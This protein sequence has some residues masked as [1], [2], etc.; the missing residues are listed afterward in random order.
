ML[1]KITLKDYVFSVLILGLFVLLVQANNKMHDLKYQ[2][3]TLV[4]EAEKPKARYAFANHG[5]DSYASERDLLQH[6]AFD[7]HSDLYHSHEEYDNHLSYG[8]HHR[9]D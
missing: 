2:V 6:K 3:D 4:Y 7:G 9:H 8:G 5:H 1:S